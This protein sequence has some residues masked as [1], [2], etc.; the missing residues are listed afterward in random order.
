MAYRIKKKANRLLEAKNRELLSINEKLQELNLTKDKFFSLIAHDLKN[1]ISAFLNNSKFLAE[2]F[3]ELPEQ[4]VVECIGDINKIALLLDNLLENLL[5]WAKSQIGL[6]PFQPE[7]IDLSEVVSHNIFSFKKEANEKNIQIISGIEPK[8]R[9]YA[10]LNSMIIIVGNL[11]SNAIK[12]T[13]PGGTIKMESRATD[14][15]VEFSIAD[16][17]RGM[18]GEEMKN[19][20]KIDTDNVLNNKS[21]SG[22]SGLGLIISKEFIERNGGTIRVESES[23]KGS[24][25]TFTVPKAK[26]FVY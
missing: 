6:I 9:V 25:F 4:E 11:L 13:S 20:F 14:S 5:I 17:G 15:H 22:G 16:N 24:T 7:V 26:Q 10:D 12:F 18:S 8:T 3:H 19:L 1:P 21:S 23:G 2:R